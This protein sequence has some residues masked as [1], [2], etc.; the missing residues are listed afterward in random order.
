MQKSLFIGA[1]ALLGLAAAFP[2]TLARADGKA[3]RKDVMGVSELKRGMKGYGLTV[4]EGT[5]P[6]RFDVEIIDVLTNFRP[7]QELILIKT[8]HPRLEVAK[9]VAG[10][11]GS[12][13]Y[14]DGKMIGAYAYGWSFGTEPVAGVTP[15]RAMLDELELPLPDTIDGWPLRLVPGRTAAKSRAP[16]RSGGKRFGGELGRYDVFEHA[17]EVKLASS[18]SDR[19]MTAVAP[20]ATPLL[21]GGMTPGAIR[22]AN[23][24]LAPLGL[25]P[26]QAGG[27]GDSIDPSAPS[28]FE[29]GGAIGVQLVR[30]DMSAMGLGTVTR[31]EGDRL[32]AFGHPMMEAGV[33]AL[34]TAVGRVAWF[35]ASE[36][37]SFKLGMPVRPV[38][39]LVN[40]RVASIV[41]SHSAAAPVV[42][43]SVSIKGV[44]GIPVSTWNFEVAHEKFMTP[45]FVAVAI[46]SGLQTVANEHQDVTWTAKSKLEIQGFGAVEL[47]DYGVAIGGTPDAGEFARSNLVR[48]IGSVLNNPWQYARIERATVAIEL[49]YSR[50]ILRLRGAELLDPEVDAGQAARVRLTLA[51]FVGPEI[52][53]TL[54]VPMPSR[55]AGK[56]VTLEIGPGYQED[57]DK[58]APNTLGE[59]VRN[60]EDPVF[61]PRSIIV[62]YSAG[63]ATVTHR[64]KIAENLPL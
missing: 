38:G 58:A 34:P 18:Q 36:Q 2:S 14:I 13:I 5:K 17:R 50:D 56:T 20:V 64:G 51:P 45:T 61:P 46:G 32:V 19:S 10:M 42:Q 15:I 23:E 28:R 35:L 1:A 25:E 31:V 8:K 4:F 62:S 9:V 22:L 52:T 39:A 24:M 3:A 41:C 59:L 57:R 54:S 16:G 11:S 53:K 29:D 12:P 63:D 37:R 21:M 6:E 30:G 26:M 7:R 27:G 49:R 55:L 40:D 47:D 44:P 33:T 60:L 43:V 48:A